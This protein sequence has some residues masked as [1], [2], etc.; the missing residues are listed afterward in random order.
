MVEPKLHEQTKSILSTRILF[1][2]RLAL[3][4]TLRAR[5]RERDPVA[6]KGLPDC[7]TA[8]VLHYRSSYLSCSTDAWVSKSPILAVLCSVLHPHVKQVKDEILELSCRLSY[9]QRQ[10]LDADLEHILEFSAFQAWILGTGFCSFNIPTSPAD[11]PSSSCR[12]LMPMLLYF[13][14]ECRI[15]FRLFLTDDLWSFDA[16]ITSVSSPEPVFLPFLKLF[17]R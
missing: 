8:M 14:S 5:N 4:M 2:L 10:K 1:L 17:N 13:V 12:I 11:F 9:L 6:A 3:R 7:R 15:G 16:K